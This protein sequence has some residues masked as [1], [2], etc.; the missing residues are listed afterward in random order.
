MIGQNGRP[1]PIPVLCELISYR[2][3]F[4]L[5][6]AV[7]SSNWI[8]DASTSSSADVDTL[9]Q[10]IPD[11][12]HHF[13][14]VSF[15][16]PTILPVARMPEPSF[17][18]LTARSRSFGELCI[19]WYA[20]PVRLLKTRLQLVHSN[21]L[22]ISPLFVSYVPRDRMLSRSVNAKKLHVSFGHETSV[23]FG[24]GPRA[25]ISSQYR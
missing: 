11:L 6:K 14:I 13:W 4:F 3:W 24:L 9:A 19:H 17:R 20:V 8:Y 18:L 16:C 21:F 25:P 7:S 5:T 1:D 2:R 12:M 10:C 22:T 15:E 23:Y